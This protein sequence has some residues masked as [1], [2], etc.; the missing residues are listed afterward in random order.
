MTKQEINSIERLKQEAWIYLSELLRDGV[1]T[2]IEMMDHYNQI[3]D[4]LSLGG[5]A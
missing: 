3:A 4:R 1:M 5:L 2:D